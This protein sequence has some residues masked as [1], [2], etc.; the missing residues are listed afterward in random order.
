M[1]VEKIMTWNPDTVTPHDSLR[2]AII[3]MK[4]GGFRR[5]PVVERQQLVGIV[6]DRDIRLATNSP[7]ILREKWHDEYLLDNVK[8]SACMTRDPITVTPDT[9][10]EEAARWAVCR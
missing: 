1:R 7:V 8:V 6:T 9:S 2:W 5:L 10:V 4:G 3:L